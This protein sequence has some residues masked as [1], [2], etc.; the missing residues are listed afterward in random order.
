MSSP[1]F[2][3]GCHQREV[4]GKSSQSLRIKRI[5]SVT[6]YCVCWIISDAENCFDFYAFID[7]GKHLKIETCLESTSTLDDNN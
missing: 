6:A 7:H 3:L 5:F 2:L 1:S 4:I